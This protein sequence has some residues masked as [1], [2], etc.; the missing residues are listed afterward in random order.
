MKYHPDKNPEG[1]VSHHYN[2]HTLFSVV[3]LPYHQAFIVCIIFSTFLQVKCRKKQVGGKGNGFRVG[4]RGLKISLGVKVSSY[5]SE[6]V[7]ELQRER[8]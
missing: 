5:F 6:S 8:H 1:R 3:V 4:K 2:H 7:K